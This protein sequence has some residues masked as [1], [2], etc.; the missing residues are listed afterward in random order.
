MKNYI[1]DFIIRRMQNNSKI[2]KISHV[3]II[4][5]LVSLLNDVSSEMIMAL[6]PMYL[7]SLGGSSISVGIVGGMEECLRS[8]LSYI[9]GFLSDRMKKRL[10]FVF[11]GYTIS[12]ISKL[13]LVLANHW[14]IVLLLRLI[15]RGGKAV[16]NPA[17]DAM[18]AAASNKQ[19][20]SLSFGIH[21]A[22]DTAGAVM[23]SVLSLILFWYLN[24]NMVSII[25]IGA[26]IAFSSLIPLIWLKEKHNPRIVSSERK[27]LEHL[28]KN[29][30]IALL[31]IFIFYLANFT[32]MLFLLKVNKAYTDKMS[33]GMPLLMYLIFN[34]TYTI[35]S[36]PA[37]YFADKWGRKK[38]IIFGYII[39]S[40][41]AMGFS[42]FQSKLWFVTLFSTYGISYA[43][44][45]VNQRAYL[46]VLTKKSIYGTMLGTFYFIS[47][48]ASLIA[49]LVAGYLWQLN[50]NY[51]FFY[52]AILSI[53]AVTLFELI[54][55]A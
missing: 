47:G 44:V 49:S 34:F 40:F 22:M 4:L 32:Y 37:G 36:I 15:D 20:M 27:K 25:F 51:P 17:R 33:I 21:R 30:W 12:S 1:L 39:Y 41:T 53:I 38:L 48:I 46:S 10:V 29:T 35:F 50:P 11:S 28:P 9:S 2:H 14:F 43:L 3:V 24:L 45:E 54:H 5:G 16:R 19:N 52:A 6:L 7:I 18:I 13:F 31:P 42:I 55:N 8:M 23:G 26:L